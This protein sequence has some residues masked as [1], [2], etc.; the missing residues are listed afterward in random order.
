MREF[1]STEEVIDF[2]I[3]EEQSAADFYTM[4]AEQVNSKSLRKMFLEFGEEELQHKYKLENIKMGSIEYLPSEEVVNLG[5]GDILVDVVPTS[6]MDYQDA[7]IFAM[8]KEKAAYQLYTRLSEIT[9][10]PVIKELL[11]GLAN[12]EANHKLRFEIE[13]D[14]HILKED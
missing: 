2:A 12:Q 11:T 13:Y 4:L 9:T 5:L 10:D 6:N 14:E 1:K 8:K 7:L 3:G